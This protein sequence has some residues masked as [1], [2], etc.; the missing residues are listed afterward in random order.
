MTNSTISPLDSRYADKL[1]SLH[2]IFSEDN[3]IRV[4]MSIEKLWI[5]YLCRH[6]V[7]PIVEFGDKLL[8]TNTDTLNNDILCILSF[9]EH[10]SLISIDQIKEIEKTTNH[11][12]VAMA[13]YVKNVLIFEGLSK[14][15]AE[16]V[17]FGL[18]SQDI[19][20]TGYNLVVKKYM[21]TRFTEIVTSLIDSMSDSK[22]NNIAFLARTHGQPAIPTSFRKEFNSYMGRIKM[23]LDNIY[24]STDN[25]STKFGGAINNF[26]A[27]K[28]C[29]KKINWELVLDTFIK[30]FIG[31]KRSHY[32]TQTDNYETLCYLF[33]NL[34]ALCNILIDLCRDIWTYCLLGYFNLEY[35]KDHVGSSTMAQKINPIDFENSEGNLEISIM[36]FR[37]LSDKLRK[38]RLQRDLSDSTIMRNIGIPFGHMDLAIQSIVR[39][40]NKINV[41]INLVTKELDMNYQILAEA[42]QTK[43]KYAGVIGAFDKVKHLFKGQ[44]MTQNDYVG[45]ILELNIGKQLQDELLDLTPVKYCY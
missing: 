21:T 43:L 32:G 14:E 7:L 41:D 8:P 15:I 12:I 13:Q 37:F 34:S 22:F 16:Y 38:S 6:T 40:F 19:V 17:H 36:W 10:N 29:N 26:A 33:D 3:I 45:V 28:S 30:N 27:A 4:Q 24:I 39:G 44:H 9:N 25:L 20:T 42:V 2:E 35:S 5:L 23:C 31:L 11:D 18:T 1:K